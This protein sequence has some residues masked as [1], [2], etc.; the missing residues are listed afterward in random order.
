MQSSYNIIGLMSGT[1]LDGLDVVACTFRQDDNRWIYDVVATQS[2]S[3]S[4]EWKQKLKE[5]H[6]LTLEDGIR[7]HV[8]YGKFLGEQVNT[9]MQKNNL[10]GLIDGIGSHGHTVLHAPDQGYTFQLGDGAAISA[11]TGLNVVNDLRSA[12]VALGGQ[13]API[14]PIG[15]KLLFPTYKIFVNIGGIVNASFHK[16]DEVI[17]Y[18]ICPGNTPLNLLAL[19]MGSDYDEGGRLASTGKLDNELL[20]RL[21]AFSFYKRDLPRSLHTYQIVNEFMPVLDVSPGT[22]NDKLRTVTE[23][24]AS[25]I[26]GHIALHARESIS[27][28]PIMITGGGALNE[29]L[30]ERIRDLSQREVYLPE[31][32]IVEYKEALVIAFIALLRMTGQTNCLAS[33]T[34]AS[35]DNTG[36]AWHAV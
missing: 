8:S 9:F 5:A 10:T 14:V 31:Q 12:D 29:F 16:W 27:K 33:V 35:K 25:Q 23:H 30:I 24:I 21:E 28:G 20:E 6:L 32:Q 4:S 22:L 2:L 36:G 1:S 15:E 19:L 17:A 3:Y 26:S 18:D 7:L 11:V 13:G 34:G